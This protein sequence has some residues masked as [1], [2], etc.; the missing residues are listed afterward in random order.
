MDREAYRAKQAERKAGFYAKTKTGKQKAA[1]RSMSGQSDGPMSYGNAGKQQP[2][3]N[4]E[5]TN[6]NLKKEANSSPEK[7]ED[8]GFWNSPNKAMGGISRKQWLYNKVSN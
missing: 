3:T 1:A 8:G 5:Q 6:A 2:W 4:R 7:K